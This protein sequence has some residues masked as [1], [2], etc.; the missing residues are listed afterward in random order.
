MNPSAHRISLLPWLAVL[1]VFAME[2]VLAQEDEPPEADV[3]E[4][5]PAVDD[6]FE[7]PEADDDE[8]LEDTDQ[9]C[10]ELERIEVDDTA[11]IDTDS[12]IDTGQAERGLAFSGDFRPLIN[13]LDRTNRVGEEHSNTNAQARIRLKGA[14][15]LTDLI[16]VGARVA[17]RC[18]SEDCDLEWIADGA[19]PQQ[20]GLEH[21]QFTFDELYVHFFRTER[22]D[23]TLGRQQTRMVLRGG[24]FSR[25]LDRNNSNN[26]N[27]TWTDGAHFVLRRRRG[28][29]GHIIVDHNQEDGSGSVRRGQLDFSP[30]SARISYFAGTE[31]RVPLGPIVQ[32]SISISYL[33]NALMVDGDID[34]RRETYIG[35]VGRMAFRWPMQ[36]EGPFF[37]GGFEIGYAPNVTTAD[38]ANLASAPDKLAWNVTASIMEFRPRQS[39]GVFYSRTGAGWLLSPNFAQ[40]EE[41]FEIRYVWRPRNF[42]AIDF[43]LR[44]R[45]DIE[46]QTNANN[47][48]ER[49][50]AFLRLTWQFDLN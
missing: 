45:E 15:R 36:S 3:M 29:E 10:L 16:G 21:G 11:D 12:T 1:L 26:T 9:R 47:K 46:Q 4:D 39:L 8:E 41:S 44:W 6:E 30:S 32:R 5:V 35:Y 25:S 18:A 50:D 33:P 31:N 13:Y 7:C 24:V 43:R 37:R 42:P 28:W 40:N 19:V 2:P 27:V 23:L 20:N 22:F 34:G 38:A 48:R 17:G 14:A 49:I